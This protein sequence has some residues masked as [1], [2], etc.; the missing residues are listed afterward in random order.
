MRS[1][2]R[3]SACAFSKPPKGTLDHLRQLER[4]AQERPL[5]LSDVKTY[6]GTPTGWSGSYRDRAWAYDWGPGHEGFMF[7]DHCTVSVQSR[8]RRV[9]K[10][11][12]PSAC[13]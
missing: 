6:V 9:T 13:R 4:C 2:Q 8:E 5:T 10:I 3:E 11:S 1:R 12:I 7:E